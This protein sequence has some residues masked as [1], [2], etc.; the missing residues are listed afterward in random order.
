LTNKISFS[1]EADF[2][3]VTKDISDLFADKSYSVT[4]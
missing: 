1:S 3:D 4:P 2:E